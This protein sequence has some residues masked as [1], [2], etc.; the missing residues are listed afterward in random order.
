MPIIPKFIASSF[1][2]PVWFVRDKFQTTENKGIT[3][4]LKQL[5]GEQYSSK[6]DLM[7]LEILS[8]VEFCTAW[9]YLERQDSESQKW[10]HLQKNLDK[11][12]KDL[13]TM[14]NLLLIQPRHK[15]TITWRGK[16]RFL[17]KIREPVRQFSEDEKMSLKKRL[18]NL[19]SMF[20]EIVQVFL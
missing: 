9:L 14:T 11:L 15:Q 12:I 18:D 19:E 1:L 16:R 3:K 7:K 10:K 2:E 4:S 17:P 13:G 20:L 8:F 6:I 5:F